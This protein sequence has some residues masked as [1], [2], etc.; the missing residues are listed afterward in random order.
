MITSLLVTFPNGRGDLETMSRGVKACS[1]ITAYIVE[2]EPTGTLLKL[3]A[4]E[5]H[6]ERLH[7]ENL[8]RGL[9]LRVNPPF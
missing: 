6:G 3:S 1:I 5:I 4:A 2:R 7:C 8:C 9:S